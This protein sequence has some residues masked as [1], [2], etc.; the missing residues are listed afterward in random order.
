M[1]GD[2]ESVV[3]VAT[4]PVRAG[5]EDAFATTYA[6]ARVLEHARGFGMCDAQLLRPYGSGAFLVVSRWP[7]RE[8]HTAWGASAQDRRLT[9]ALAPLLVGAPSSSAYRVVERA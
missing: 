2:A 6:R 4:L 5:R 1:T 3:A 7:S 8:C 9:V